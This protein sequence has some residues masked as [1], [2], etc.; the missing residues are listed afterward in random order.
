M[1]S[2]IIHDTENKFFILNFKG[3]F[4]INMKIYAM[5]DDLI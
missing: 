5:N 3:V 1:V 2:I 4:N